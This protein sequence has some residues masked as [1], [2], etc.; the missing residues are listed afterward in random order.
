MQKIAR[1]QFTNIKRNKFADDQADLILES[2]DQLVDFIKPTLG[3]KVKHILVQHGLDIQI[4]DDGKKIAEEMLDAFDDENAEAIVKFVVEVL[5]KTDDRVGDGTTT[6]AVLLQALVHEI[7]NSGKKYHEYSK[8]LNT[9][10]EEVSKALE[11]RAKKIETVGDLEKVAKTSVLDDEAAKVISETLFGVGSDGSVTIEKSQELGISSDRAEGYEFG[12]GWVS[13]YMV[14]DPEHGAATLNNPMIV[15]YDGI[16]STEADAIKVLEI[17]SQLEKKEIL[18]IAQDFMGDALK[19]FILNRM[20]GNATS[21]CVKA[22]LAGEPQKEYLFDIALVTGAK[23]LGGSSGI[24]IR[25]ITAEN[26]GSAGKVIS[27]KED[28]VIISGEGAKEEV[29]KHIEFLKNQSEGVEDAGYK[30]MYHS[31]M[32]RLQGGVAVIRVGAAT[33]TEL[34]SKLD[35]VEDAVNACKGALEEGI[36][37]GGGVAFL[38]IKTSSEIMNKILSA[39]FK[40]ICEN[41]ELTIDP[42]FGQDETFDALT[43]QRGNYLDLGVVDSVKVL[44][45][46]LQNAISIMTKLANVTGLIVVKR[47]HDCHC[48]A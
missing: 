20:R 18:I 21:V 11:G 43:G 23:V 17:G 30:E 8:E 9:A 44:K 24:K 13:P 38:G 37:A 3:P 12:R 40:Q 2:V 14:N 36:V 28:T 4:R 19:I 42:N 27:T 25:N 31:R 26:V 7:I 45:T 34:E 32:A 22:P 1:K 46:A 35:K 48:K 16:I 5:Q 47:E 41:A 29:Q 15:V 6:S 33:E 39:P 10:F